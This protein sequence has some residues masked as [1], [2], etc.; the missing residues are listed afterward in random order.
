M[1]AHKLQVSN[2]SSWSLEGGPPPAPGESLT[3]PFLG[4]L[5]RMGGGASRE[6]SPPGL[7]DLPARTNPVPAAL[8]C[9]GRTFHLS[10]GLCYHS[11]VPGGWDG[12]LLETLV[13]TPA[14]LSHPAPALGCI[15]LALLPPC[16]KN[17]VE[18]N[19]ASLFPSYR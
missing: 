9:A 16:Y 6:H 18:P 14:G 17:P 2:D 4:G 8:A 1:Q 19:D 7:R 10:L 15:S 12:G 5:G 13:Q 3:T 11:G